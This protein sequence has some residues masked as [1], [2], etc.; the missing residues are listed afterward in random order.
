MLFSVLIAIY[1]EIIYI[2]KKKEIDR[3]WLKI[4]M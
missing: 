3:A 4:L 2:Q 1:N